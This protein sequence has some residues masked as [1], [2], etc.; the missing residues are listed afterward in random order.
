MDLSR[1]GMKGLQQQLHLGSQGFCLLYLCVSPYA[2]AQ[3]HND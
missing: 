2:T 1:W 3:T